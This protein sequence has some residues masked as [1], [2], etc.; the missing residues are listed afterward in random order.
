MI[1]ETT[2]QVLVFKKLSIR[3]KIPFL[4]AWWLKTLPQ[5]LVLQDNV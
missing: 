3:L 5:H 4:V 2:G 1:Q